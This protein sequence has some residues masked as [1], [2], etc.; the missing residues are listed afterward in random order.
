MDIMTKLTRSAYQK[1][2]DEDL[3]WLDTLPRTLER[4]HVR[5]IVRL[6]PKH[7]YGEYQL[8]PPPPPNYYM[9]VPWFARL[10][11]LRRKR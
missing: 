6:S 9:F 8:S 4:D 7:E 5:E 2:I 1:L 3:A 11:A 10:D